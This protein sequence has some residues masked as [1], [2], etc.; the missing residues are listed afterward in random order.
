MST[1]T[2]KKVGTAA[3]KP[4][5]A[6]KGRPKGVPNKT[7]ALLRDAILL[8][9]EE[10]GRDGKGKEGLLGYLKR[11]AVKDHKAYA[12]LLAKILPT[13]VTGEGGGPLLVK[14][15]ADLSDNELAAIARRSRR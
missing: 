2:S 8:A 11:I 10:V 5:A 15:A 14:N 9:A 7:T 13:Q 6:G 3:R 1:E 4:P 12:T